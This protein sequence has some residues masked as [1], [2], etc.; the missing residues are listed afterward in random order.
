M[1]YP[2]EIGSTRRDGAHA[3]PDLDVIVVGAGFAGLYAL[4]KLRK[5]GLRAQALEAGSGI[6]G[7]WFWNRYPGA[8]CDVDSVEYSYSFSDELQQEWNWPERFSAQ[9]DILRYINHVADRFDLRRDIRLNTRVQSASF[10]APNGVWRVETVDGQ[11]V[12]AR[13]CVMATGNLSL[14]RVPEFKGLDTFKGDWYHTGL[15]PDEPVDFTGRRVGV[16]GTGSSG[17]QVI[18]IVAKQASELYVFQRT[19]NFTLPARNRALT[20]D[21]LGRHKARYEFWRA[22]AQNTPFGIAGHAAPTKNALDDTPEDR[23]ATFEEKWKAGG[24]ISFLYAYK[25]LLTNQAANDTAAEF[26]RNKIR[27][28][29][30]DPATAELLVPKDYPIGARRLCLDTGY[31]E[32][33]NLP[34]VKLVDTKSAPIVEITETGVKTATGDYAL[35]TI[36]FATGFDAITGA[37]ADIDIRGRDGLPLKQKW[38]HGPRTYLGLMTAGFPNLFIVT[39]P[40]SPSVK[41]N[42]VCAIEQHMNWITDCI[43]KL[44]AHGTSTIEPDPEAETRWVEHVN[45]VADATLYPLAESWYTGANVPGKPRVFMPY[46]GGFHRYRAICDEVV[47]DDY[48]GF[49]IADGQAAEA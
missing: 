9:G 10:D 6:G 19:A 43:G 48:R 46:V 5:L 3:A 37:L 39:G 30:K 2:D 12:T 38:V 11:V 28:T 32:T 15:W 4:Y 21:E 14:P 31:Y 36:V 23:L 45:E 42:M 33:F 34:N 49:V 17:I 29:V 7:T 16:I 18:P 1:Q 40:G 27:S 26:V 22:E 44:A 24:S 13:F 35:D 47:R 8:R 41:S 20:G 25:D